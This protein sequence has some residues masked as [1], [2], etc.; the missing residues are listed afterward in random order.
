[1]KLT[2]DTKRVQ[3]KGN[4][5]VLN[6]GYEYREQVGCGGIGIL[7]YLS[8]KYRHS[9]VEEWKRRLADGEIALDGDPIGTDRVLR[10]GQ[11]L[12]WRRPPWNEPDVPLSFAVLYRDEDLLAVAKPRGLPTVPAGGFLEHTLFSLVRRSHPEATPIHRLGR[13]TS[14]VVLFARTRKARS[15]L[16]ESIRLN[17]V[18]KTYRALACGV[19]AEEN[20][21][22]DAPIGP[23][24]HP[25]LGQV[26]AISSEGKPA[27][28]H[29]LLLE[30]RGNASL[31][32]VRIETGKPHQI[33][34]HLAAA[35][36]P[37]VGDPLYTRGGVP[38]EEGR[39][40][41]GDCGYFLHAE[42]LSLCHP[43]SGSRVE[44][45]CA[46]PQQLRYAEEGIR[47]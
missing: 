17:R 28:S 20:F 35:G 46:P 16:C 32:E 6:K 10:P 40:L 38:K 44:I 13:G 36:Y 4:D 42:L 31:L 7:E 29:V 25:I 22:I 37:L 27:M 24:P 1:M 5:L 34:I 8:S 21:S 23:V 12:T 3:R 33:R 26:Y 39:A 19:P 30:R 11:W 45:W 14:G 2:K 47:L 9:G 43:T 18:V 41:P 15:I